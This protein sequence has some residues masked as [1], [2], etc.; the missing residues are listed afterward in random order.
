MIKPPVIDA[1]AV[2]RKVNPTC[3]YAS[4]LDIRKVGCK[5]PSVF[6]LI[7]ALPG[8]VVP[9]LFGHP[10]EVKPYSTACVLACRS[11]ATLLWNGWREIIL[12]LAERETGLR[13]LVVDIEKHPAFRTWWET[14]NRAAADRD[15]VNAMLRRPS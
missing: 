15:L 7:A 13:P 6:L 12:K 1:P 5:N 8:K 11:H 14:N 2:I 10:G 3:D 9:V 4:E